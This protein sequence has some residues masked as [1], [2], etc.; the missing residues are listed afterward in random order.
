MYDFALLYL[1]FVIIAIA[2]IF[3]GTKI[4]SRWNR[5]HYVADSCPSSEAIIH[6]YPVAFFDDEFGVIIDQ[7]E[8]HPARSLGRRWL[9]VPD[10]APCHPFAWYDLPYAPWPRKTQDSGIKTGVNDCI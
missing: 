6:N 5:W 1:A 10:G 2:G 9:T 8:Y 3:V 4:E 7:A